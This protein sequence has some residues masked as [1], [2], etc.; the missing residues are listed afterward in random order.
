M[1]KCLK[2]HKKYFK[3]VKIFWMENLNIITDCFNFTIFFGP[4]KL[5]WE[6]N[7]QQIIVSTD[8]SFI[9]WQLD[10]K[11]KLCLK[12]EKWKVKLSL[13][14]IIIQNF[15]LKFIQTQVIKQTTC[16]HSCLSWFALRQF[17]LANQ[18]RKCLLW[19]L[20]LRLFR[21]HSGIKVGHLTPRFC[22]TH[23]KDYHSTFQVAWKNLRGWH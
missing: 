17:C 16:F 9:T 22:R 7:D 21:Q 1:Q 18:D 23:L 3:T 14:S 5:F 12:S 6:V 4:L 2:T 8:Y 10:W 20:I 15:Y 11:W 19:P 13:R